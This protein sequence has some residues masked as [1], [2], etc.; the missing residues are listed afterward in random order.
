MYLQVLSGENLLV[1][2]ATP[3]RL[4]LFLGGPGLKGLFSGYASRSLGKTSTESRY[5]IASYT[6]TVRSR[7]DA[8]SFRRK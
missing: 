5:L 6:I 3:T 4:F 8:Y 1:L 7:C 2:A